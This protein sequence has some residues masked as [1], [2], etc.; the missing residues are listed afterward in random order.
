MKLAKNRK[1]KK[2]FIALNLHIKLETEKAIAV[3]TDAN[4]SRDF[5]DGKLEDYTHGKKLFWIPKSLSHIGTVQGTFSE[6][7]EKQDFKVI[8]VPA[9]LFHKNWDGHAFSHKEVIT[10][11][12][13]GPFQKR[14]H[15]KIFKIK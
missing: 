4:H 9:W 3:E 11:A 5:G 1:S 2:N 15:K 13:F 12:G 8:L 10:E 14:K 6:S 7:N